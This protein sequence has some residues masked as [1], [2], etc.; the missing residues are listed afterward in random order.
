MR[1]LIFAALALGTACAPRYA[2]I[3]IE[4]EE[5]EEVIDEA[6]Y[7]GATLRIVEPS[8]GEFLPLGKN[9]EFVAELVSAEGEPITD[10]GPITWSSNVDDQWVPAP[11]LV[12]EDD[13]LDVG[14]HDITAEVTLPNGDRLAHTVG[15]ILLQSEYAGIYAGTFTADVVTDEFTLGCAGSTL[16]VV[17]PFGEVVAGDAS[18]IVSL[19]GYEVDLMFLFDLENDEGEMEGSAAADLMGWYQL[20]FDAVGAVN[21]D[22]ELTLEFGGDEGSSGFLDVSGGLVADRVSRDTET[23]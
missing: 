9:H 10:A 20:E 18:C 7:A 13:T 14:V 21:D 17:D 4:E 6:R 8:S 5:Q 23:E 15:G 22:G 1:S 3:E 12:F 11:E 16:L 19:F 2:I